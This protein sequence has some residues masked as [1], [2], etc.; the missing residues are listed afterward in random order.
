[1]LDG[2]YA[3]ARSTVDLLL[4]HTPPR[5]EAT[6]HLELLR[7][8]ARIA[9]LQHE[10]PRAQH[11]AASALAAARRMADPGQ[12]SST[13]MEY[14]N[15]Q[16]AAGAAAQAIAAFDELLALR[17]HHLGERHVNVAAVH[18]ALSRAHRRAGANDAA[19]AHAAA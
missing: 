15:A 6:L 10:L 18:T 9:S 1:F 5:R 3:R 16:L 14:G 8:S 11:D 2:D 17:R 19:V 12:L 7:D 4:R 13:L